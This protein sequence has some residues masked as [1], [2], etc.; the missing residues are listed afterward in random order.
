MDNIYSAR[1]RDVE[2]RI[3]GKSHV[4]DFLMIFAFIGLIASFGCALLF[5]ESRITQACFFLLGVFSVLVRDVYL[6]SFGSSDGTG[7]S[8]WLLS[9]LRSWIKK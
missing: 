4:N 1:A 8:F 9:I 7:A 2:L 5:K 3:K 6:F